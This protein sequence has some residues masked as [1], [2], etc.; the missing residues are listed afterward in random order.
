MKPKVPAVS[1]LRMVC[2]GLILF[3]LFFFVVKE[4]QAFKFWRNEYSRLFKSYLEVE[5]IS[6]T[7]LDVNEKILMDISDF[8]GIYSPFEN[9]MLGDIRFSIYHRFVPDMKIAESIF[10]KGAPKMRIVRVGRRRQFRPTSEA[11]PKELTVDYLS[12]LQ[13]L[14][15][16]LEANDLAYVSLPYY[17][18][19]WTE[20]LRTMEEN[21]FEKI[22]GNAHY[23][24]FVLRPTKQ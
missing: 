8:Q 13:E 1:T 20:L 23:M 14:I 18:I 6:H 12:H 2:P 5:Y 3:L 24:L 10:N 22:Y 4:D 15:K 7:Q 9:K 21:G 16:Y 19:G 11:L 17:K